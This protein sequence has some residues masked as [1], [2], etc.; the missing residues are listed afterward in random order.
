MRKLLIVIVC[1]SS[2]TVLL[3]GQEIPY[4]PGEKATYYVRYGPVT[5]GYASFEINWDTLKGK[6]V[7]HSYFDCHTIGIAD[8]FYRIKDIYESYIEPESELPLLSIRNVQE[9]HYRRYNTVL[10]DRVS[11]KDSAILTSNLTGRHITQK[12]IHDVI[13]FFYSFRKNWLAKNYQFKK[14]EVI[15]IMTWFTDELFPIRLVYVGTEDVKT[16]FGKIT[17]LKFNPVT[18]VG[19]LFKTNDDVSIWFSADKNYLPVKVRFDIFVGAFTA[20]LLS[21]EGLVGPLDIKGIE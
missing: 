17:C 1:I 21:Y 19:R 12:D 9:G 18:E 2:L 10:F 20:E 14:N 16:K 4:K 7:L 6:E 3:R 13:S 11:R 8:V 5:G 15:T